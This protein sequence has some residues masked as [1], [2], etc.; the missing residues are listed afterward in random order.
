M[1]ENEKR[2]ILLEVNKKIE[3]VE[4]HPVTVSK[5]CFARVSSG[6]KFECQK[7]QCIPLYKCFTMKM[8]TRLNL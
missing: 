7:L 3:M 8:Y 5:G 1:D 2:G 4:F 6:T